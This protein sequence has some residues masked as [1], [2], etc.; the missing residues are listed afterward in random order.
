[1]K[2]CFLFVSIISV[3]LCRN[4][5]GFEIKGLQPVDPY[6][7]FSTF[8]AE[9][10]SKGK[11]AVSTGAE[12][13]IDPDFYRLIFKTAY[14][15]KDNVEL[16]ITIP[17]VFGS[18]SVDAFEDISLGFKHRFFE[19]GKYGPSLAYLITA[20]IPTGRDEIS[21]DG[22]YGAGF[23]MSKRV[24]PVN[25]HFNLFYIESGTK[26]L[27]EEISFLAGLDF[28]ASHNFKI[29]AELYCKKS[30]WSENI[31]LIE[32]RFGYRIKT[33]DFIYTTFGAGFD[34]KNRN[35]ETRI[36]FLVTFL[37][38]SEKKEVKKIYEE[39]Q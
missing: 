1:M 26:S 13:S 25:G 9:S 7:I 12:I 33:T 29:L 37:S 31:D 2:K 35:P 28:S 17:F 15:V 4:T 39:E 5:F 30:N 14:G 19:E 16:E 32:G 11:V 18:A 36:M 27:D 20:S 38:P 8:S 24:G 34:F 23:I 10:L 21:T 6:G 3:I 22:R